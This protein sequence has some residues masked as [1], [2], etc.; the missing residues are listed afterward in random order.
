LN[1]IFFFLPAGVTLSP[2]KTSFGINEDIVIDF[3]AP[4]THST[5][6]RIYLYK[7]DY[8]S[9]SDDLQVHI[10]PLQLKF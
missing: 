7:G 10:F 9:A 2:S 8:N 5:D 3:T 6:D 1:I 4:A